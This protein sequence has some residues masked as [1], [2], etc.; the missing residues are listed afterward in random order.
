MQ[1]EPV[2]FL[3]GAGFCVDSAY[4]AGNPTGVEC[5][6]KYPLV[7]ELLRLCFGQEFLPP[8]KSIEDLFQ[9]S[10]DKRNLK[11]R[12]ILYETLMESDYYVTPHLMPDGSHRENV[13][14]RFFDDF[15]TSTLITFNYDSLP[16]ILLLNKKAWRPEDGYGVPVRAEFKSGLAS[17][18]SSF[19]AKSQRIIL[20]LHG[21]LC[22]YPDEFYTEYD[23]GSKY[24]IL[25]EKER[26]EYIFD[27]DI[28]G[29]RFFPFDRIPPTQNYRYK[30]ERVIAP[31]PDKAN[32]L[33]NNFI[34]AVYSQA[35][36]LIRNANKVIV[37]G[38]SFSP[39]D[40]ASYFPLLKAA[41]NKR[42]LIVSP[43]AKSSVQRLKDKSPRIDWRWEAMSFREWVINGYP[44][45]K[46]K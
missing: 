11:P 5:P 29:H 18:E 41:E 36:N 16:E 42:I 8:N 19:P 21:S 23:P 2:I 37:I 32:I 27:P 46:Q 26:L 25:R 28:I 17:N 22:I 33:D 45:V 10:I 6:A 44:G 13:Y 31:V 38:Y 40:Q 12:K 30:E 43:D 34:K 39:N 14:M 3:L 9:E 4:E 1:D 35:I 15:P 24:G 20:H 7:H